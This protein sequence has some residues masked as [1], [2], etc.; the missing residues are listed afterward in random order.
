MNTSEILQDP[1]TSN[2]R[3]FTFSQTR[4]AFQESGIIFSHPLILFQPQSL[5]C[6]IFFLAGT[7]PSKCTAEGPGLHDGIKDTF[8]A[9]FKVQ[10]RDRDGLPITEGGDD[11]RPK[12]TDPDG[13]DVP[14]E[15]KDNGDGTYDVVYHPDKPG[16]HKSMLKAKGE[17]KER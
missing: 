1:S 16:P 3:H 17:M 14:C 2:V 9:H 8:P 7:D 10:A 15:I 5:Q 11:F 6:L 12:V 4:F 13:K